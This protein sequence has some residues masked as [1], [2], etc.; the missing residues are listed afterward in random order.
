[1]SGSTERSAIHAL[2]RATYTI[3]TQVD[4]L[5]Q[6]VGVSGFASLD[7]KQHEAR[8]ERCLFYPFRSRLDERECLCERSVGYTR[9]ASATQ[10]S[11]LND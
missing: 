1:M 7:D 3:D 10:H 8:E 9:R 11:L 2:G 5:E 6:R 4:R